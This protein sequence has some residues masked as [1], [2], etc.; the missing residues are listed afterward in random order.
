MKIEF[1]AKSEENLKA[2]K[3][4]LDNNMI[5][6]KQQELVDNLIQAVKK[7]FPEIQL[8]DISES[9]EDPNDL[10]VNVT[11]P[12]DENRK[13]ELME[14]AANLETDILLDYGYHIMLMPTNNSNSSADSSRPIFTA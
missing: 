4:L 11:F 7:K 3:I 14:Y 5:N 6:F 8:V 1:L 12:K 10:W 13:I 9:P 2:A